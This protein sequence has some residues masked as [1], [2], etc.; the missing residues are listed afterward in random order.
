MQVKK[1]SRANKDLNSV[2][3]AVGSPT[4]DI[5]CILLTV[6]LFPISVDNLHILSK[7]MITIPMLI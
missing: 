1:M 3:K 2:V 6:K 4:L 7:M 5:S